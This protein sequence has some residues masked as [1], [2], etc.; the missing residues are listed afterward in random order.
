MLQV[1]I[2]AGITMLGGPKFKQK[3]KISIDLQPLPLPSSANLSAV[4]SPSPCLV[5][6]VGKRGEKSNSFLSLPGINLHFCI[7]A[8]TPITVGIDVTAS[9]EQRGFQKIQE[10]SGRVTGTKGGKE[11]G[12]LRGWQGRVGVR[13][14]RGVPITG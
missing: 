12:P 1:C 5:K 2:G 14:R 3:T 4:C 6:S 8:A 7:Y 10:R 11:K 9:V 13:H